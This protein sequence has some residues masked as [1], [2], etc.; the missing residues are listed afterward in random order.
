MSHR[1]WILVL[2]LLI[3]LVSACTAGASRQP[4]PPIPT[5]IDSETWQTIPAGDF[6]YGPHNESAVTEQAFEMMVTDVTNAQYARFL[7]ES[8]S[9]SA[10][11]L[12]DQADLGRVAVGDYPGDQFHG[13]KHEMEIKAGDYL[14]VPLQAK[15]LRVIEKDGQYQPAAGYEDHPV[16]MVTWFGA[17]AYCQ[18][19]GWRLPSEL[20]WEKAARGTDGRAYPWGDEISPQ[21]ANYY[22]S[23]TVFQKLFGA[24]DETTPVGLY[25]G[26]T[27]HNHFTTLNSAS[28]YGIYDMAGNVWQWVADVFEGTHYRYLRGGSKTDYGYNL[29]SWTR[30][31]AAPDYFSPNVGFRCVR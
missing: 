28:P 17:R 14:L 23:Q 29:R 15:G 13:V 24:S 20:E 2:T 26:R 4:L 7:N 3:I 9:Q 5:G 25:N 22:S 18:F 12:Q 6:L 10:I 8:L 21:N 27:Y 31:S 19:Y 30:N 1:R 16:V 11:K